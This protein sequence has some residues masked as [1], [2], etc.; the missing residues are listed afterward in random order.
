MLKVAALFSLGLSTPFLTTN[1]LA[2]DIY[3]VSEGILYSKSDLTSIDKVKGFCESLNQASIDA[4]ELRK[5]GWKEP[6]KEMNALVSYVEQKN[7]VYILKQGARRVSYTTQIDQPVRA[8]CQY[9]QGTVS[10]TERAKWYA[11]RVDPAYKLYV[12][13]KEGIW[14]NRLNADYELGDEVCSYDNKLGYV[15]QVTD[16]KQKV[17]WKG[18]VAEVGEGYFFGQRDIFSFKNKDFSYERL[19]DVRWESKSQVAACDFE[20]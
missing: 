10:I 17:L 7:R 19:D 14:S 15:E 3:G 4:S 12:A 1:T 18:Q 9:D 6:F 2:N 13:A 8:V 16:K 20:L 11:N 5:V